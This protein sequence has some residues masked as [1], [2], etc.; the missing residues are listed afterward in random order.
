MVGEIRD[1]K[2]ANMA[3]RAALTGHLV[4]STIHTNSAW[5]TI[6]RLI[7]M[8][9]PPFLIASTL[10]VSVA[11][12]LV[13]KLCNYCKEENVIHK[14]DFPLGFEIP[15]SLEKIYKPKGCSKCY[16]TG[17]KGRK[18]IYEI[19]PI[20]KELVESIEL[21]N[22]DIEKYLQKNNIATLKD[23]G[24]S[25]VIEGATSIEEIYSL[26]NE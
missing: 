5:A 26:L 21:R 8:G 11:Q 2:T 16:H 12:R 3:I 9:I 17:Y 14:N 13:R 24:L 18:A 1:V 20:S 19:I 10:N 4:L 25:L 23:N 7:D 6:S 22:N 15:K